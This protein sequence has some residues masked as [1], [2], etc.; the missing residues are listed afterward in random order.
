MHPFYFSLMLLP[1]SS[2]YSGS[3]P[4]LD[5]STGPLPVTW[6]WSIPQQTIELDAGTALS[7]MWA[8]HRAISTT[9]LEKQSVIR[10]STGHA[11]LIQISNL[12]NGEGICLESCLWGQK[13]EIG[14]AYTK[15]P[16]KVF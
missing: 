9:S 2:F 16:H 7:V 8:C 14:K 6:Y 12:R 13:G 3:P 1:R 10:H 15:L 11:L 4:G 5:H